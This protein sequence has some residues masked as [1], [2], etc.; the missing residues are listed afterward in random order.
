MWIVIF[1]NQECLEQQILKVNKLLSALKFLYFFLL[2]VFIFYCIP[3]K[4]MLV[5]DLDADRPSLSKMHMLLLYL[6]P[7][8]SNWS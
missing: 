7:L 5:T 4:M 1:L 6:K 3:F 2:C 8:S